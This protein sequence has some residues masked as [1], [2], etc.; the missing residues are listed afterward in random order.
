MYNKISSWTDCNGIKVEKGD[1][2]VMVENSYNSKDNVGANGK[3]VEI[4][5]YSYHHSGCVDDRGEGWDETSTKITIKLE[6][7]KICDVCTGRCFKKVETT[8][9]LFVVKFK[10]F[11]QKDSKEG[12]KEYLIAKDDKQ[13]FDYLNNT[14][15]GTY[16]CW[17]YDEK[18]EY[19]KKVMKEILENKGTKFRTP[20]DL[21]YGF[22]HWWW[23]EVSINVSELT[24]L[25]DLMV[26]N[27]LAK[28][29]A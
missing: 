15:N 2:V 26:K 9:K 28:V 19:D 23:E 20:S 8:N 21:Y 4:E 1:T 5:H 13:I 25:T 14:V 10:H 12:V 22:T 3:I 17:D 24:A 27:S 6:D 7:G 11:S 18:N 16:T 29:L